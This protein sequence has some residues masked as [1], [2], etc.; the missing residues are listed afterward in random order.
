LPQQELIKSGI[1]SATRVEV[2]LLCV[3]L[4]G[5]WGVQTWKIPLNHRF[6]ELVAAASPPKH[7]QTS[8]H[9]GRIIF[10]HSA[11]STVLPRGKQVASHASRWSCLAS[12]RN[13]ASPEA[14]RNRGAVG[15][16]H[17]RAST[18]LSEGVR[19]RKLAKNLENP[20]KT[21]RN[22]LAPAASWSRKVASPSAMPLQ[23]PLNRV[24]LLQTE[25][26]LPPQLKTL[27]WG[28]AFLFFQKKL[29]RGET[30]FPRSCFPRGSTV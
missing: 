22:W 3:F 27:F 21:L 29:L 19:V 20:A 8:I 11:H 4:V 12:N 1:I 24:A 6:R 10:Y 15:A 2:V 30:C 9:L 18:P 14:N 5:R 17:F 23:T 7:P 16:S 13:I 26:L 28:A 25:K